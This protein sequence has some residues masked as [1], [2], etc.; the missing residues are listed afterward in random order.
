M[1][2]ASVLIGTHTTPYLLAGESL[3]YLSENQTELCLEAREQRFAV[4]NG[5][6]KRHPLPLNVSGS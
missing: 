2:D 1:F 4:S 3:L 5:N 6:S